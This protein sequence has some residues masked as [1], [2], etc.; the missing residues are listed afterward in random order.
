MSCKNEL[1]IVFEVSSAVTDLNS[2]FS[3]LNV[4]LELVAKKLGTRKD[5]RSFFAS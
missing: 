4:M 2:G 3:D 5:M 1:V